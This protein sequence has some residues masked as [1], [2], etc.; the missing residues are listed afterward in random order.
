MRLG[1]QNN[2]I[3]R[4]N[5][6]SCIMPIQGKGVYTMSAST[7]TA[8]GIYTEMLVENPEDLESIWM[9]NF[10][11]MTL[12]EYPQKVP[13]KFRLPASFFKSDI[14]IPAFKN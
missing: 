9:L 12:G 10:A 4:T 6:E 8:I 1:E 3:E 5:D 2:C 14:E 13:T 7:K 11:Y